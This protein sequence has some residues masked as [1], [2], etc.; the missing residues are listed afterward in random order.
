MMCIRTYDVHTYVFGTLRNVAVTSR[1]NVG[2]MMRRGGASYYNT[3]IDINMS[4]EMTAAADTWLAGC[5]NQ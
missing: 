4:L 3:C 2:S 1:R 5:V